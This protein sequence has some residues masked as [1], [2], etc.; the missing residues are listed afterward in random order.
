M[1]GSG[2]AD[3][4][5]VCYAKCS[6]VKILVGRSSARAIC[7]QNLVYLSLCKVILSEIK[8]SEEEQTFLKNLQT[9]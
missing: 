2:L 7:G 5:G 4:L 3:M 1:C 9:I 8:F 6:V